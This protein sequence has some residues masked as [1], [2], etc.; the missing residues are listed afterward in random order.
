MEVRIWVA[1]IGLAGAIDEESLVPLS[2]HAIDGLQTV[3]V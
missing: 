1:L 2:R 3:F